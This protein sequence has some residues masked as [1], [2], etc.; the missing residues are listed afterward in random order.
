MYL[1][2]LLAR[3]EDAVGRPDVVL[4]EESLDVLDERRSHL[5][6]KVYHLLALLVD[7]GL[8][9]LL[10]ELLV[11]DEVLRRVDYSLLL[12]VQLKDDLA[13]VYDIALPEALNGLPG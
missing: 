8:G 9:Q 13:R 7:D 6:V 5:V 1:L 10:L 4:L 3:V 12:V 11:D 2:E